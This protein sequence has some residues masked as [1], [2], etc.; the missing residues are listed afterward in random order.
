[1]CELQCVVLAA[2]E[3]T[4]FL[5]ML[6]LRNI[7]HIIII[8]VINLSQFA[9]LHSLERAARAC[10]ERVK[11][12]ARACTASSDIFYTAHVCYSI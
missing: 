9:G 8:I 11:D 5:T 6:I 12:T 3:R 1:M 2:F 4:P 7:W 10:T